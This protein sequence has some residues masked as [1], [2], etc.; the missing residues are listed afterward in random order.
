MDRNREAPIDREPSKMESRVNGQTGPLA[1]PVPRPDLSAYLADKILE[2]IENQ[3]MR[4]G[5]R[6]PST[7][8]L[9]AHFSVAEP[10]L[11]QAI[12]RLQTNGVLDIRHGSGTYVRSRH[13]RLVLT[14]PHSGSLENRVLLQLVEARLL[15]EPHLAE[16]AATHISD[17]DLETLTQLL[18]QTEP[19]LHG[20]GK[21]AQRPENLSLFHRVNQAFH[22]TIAR[23]S[24]NTVLAE[25]VES[26]TEVHSFERLGM[27]PPGDRTKGLQEHIRILNALRQRDGR[28]AREEM[29]HHIQEIRLLVEIGHASQG[30]GVKARPDG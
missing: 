26:L 1:A 2:L 25:I 24:G 27:S 14:N 19:Y 15:I 6:L 29:H 22:S 13:E 8:A 23:A 4:E 9:A 30:A 5:D 16:L 17:S 20:D 10:T 21:Q 7:K 3:D 18:R 28:Q 11:R 12:R